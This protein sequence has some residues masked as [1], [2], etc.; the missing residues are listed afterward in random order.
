MTTLFASPL[1]VRIPYAR[2]H[3]CGVQSAYGSPHSHDVMNIFPDFNADPYAPESY[4][5]VCTDASVLTL[6]DAANKPTWG[7]T[8]A[9]FFDLYEIRAEKQRLTLTVRFTEV[10]YSQRS[11]FTR[12]SCP[13]ATRSRCTVLCTGPTAA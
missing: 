6:D 5:S 4:D 12:Y 3:D 9:Q 13:R 7:G 8:R 2:N 1:V 10:M 11:R